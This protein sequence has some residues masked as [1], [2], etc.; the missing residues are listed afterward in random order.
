MPVVGEVSIVE[1]VDEWGMAK[2][3]CGKRSKHRERVIASLT[4]S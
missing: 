4:E 3:R 2:G 1:G